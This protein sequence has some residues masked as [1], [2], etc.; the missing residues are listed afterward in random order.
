MKIVIIPETEAEKAKFSTS[1]HENVKEFFVFGNKTDA[2][3][4]G[5][6]FHEWNGSYRYLQ[7]SLIWYADMV[8]DAKRSDA[9]K[10]EQMRSYGPSIN[11]PVTQAPH[12]MNVSP[13]IEP[14]SPVSPI[15]QTPDVTEVVEEPAPIVEDK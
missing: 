14:V 9:A 6:D 2:D 10:A 8:K 13:R 12:S 4:D 15:V 5:I 7:G 1:E 11:S 3:R